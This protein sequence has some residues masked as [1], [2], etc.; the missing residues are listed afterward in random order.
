MWVQVNRNNSTNQF[1]TFYGQL[2]WFV[3]GEHKEIKDSYS[4]FKR[5]RPNKNFGKSTKGS[6]ELALRYS[7]VDMNNGDV[8]GGSQKDVT[9][10][11][12]WYLNSNVRCMYNQVYAN[13]VDKGN[14]NVSQFRVQVDF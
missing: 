3:T 8:L 14:I 2:S 6:W 12:N 5:L 9:L 1:H 10:G 13:V 7:Y 11:L 4:G